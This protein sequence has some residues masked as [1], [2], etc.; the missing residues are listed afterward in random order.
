[1]SPFWNTL[2]EISQLTSTHD[3]ISQNLI[4]K[5]SELIIPD[6][7]WATSIRGTLHWT[8][9]CL[10]IPLQ[11]SSIAVGSRAFSQRWFHQYFRE[12]KMKKQFHPKKDNTEKKSKGISP[13]PPYSYFLLHLRSTST[14]PHKT[15]CFLSFMR[16]CEWSPQ[17]PLQNRKWLRTTA[18]AFS[19]DCVM[20]HVWMSYNHTYEWVVQ[21]VN[22][23]WHIWK[24]HVTHMNESCHTH[25]WVMSLTWISHVTYMDA[26]CHAYAWVMSHIWM[27]QGTHTNESRHTYEWVMSHEWMNHG[28]HMNESCHTYERIMAHIWMSLEPSEWCM[29]HERVMTH[30]NGSCHTYE[31][32]MSHIRMS[33]V[34]HMHESWHT[35][36]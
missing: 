15:D 8:R 31:W 33:H 23:S 14:P 1:M 36:I 3:L 12:K 2:T 21:H 17:Y 9:S 16:T 25:E 10:L 5:T 27:S 24:S 22:D 6:S 28:T 35:H 26:S 34:T 30:M 11:F 4:Q 20:S 32:V 7:G 19:L 13:S 29:T 18:I